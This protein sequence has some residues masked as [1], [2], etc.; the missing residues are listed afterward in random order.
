MVRSVTAVNESLIQNT[1]LKYVGSATIGT[2]HL[3]IQALEKHSITWANAAGCNAQAVAEYVITALLHLDASL[4]EQQE[5]FTLGIVGLGNV[6]KRLAYM[7]QLLGWKVIGFDPYVQLDS[8]EN[9]SFQTLLQ[10]ANAVSIH[11]PLTKKANM[12]RIICLTKKLLQR[13]NRTRF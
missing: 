1:A 11:V 3:D 7:A 10:Q 6:G 4:L 12:R 13:F 9:V 2:D 5:K 8:I